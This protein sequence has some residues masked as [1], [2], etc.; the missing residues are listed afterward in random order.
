MT[1]L[2]AAREKLGGGIL[3]RPRDVR[4]GAVPP[5]RQVGDRP[6]HPGRLPDPP[7][8]KGHPVGGTDEE[9]ARLG[10]EGGGHLGIG[11][12][13]RPVRPEGAAGEA[14]GGGGGGGGGGAGGG[15]GR[16]LAARPGAR[17]G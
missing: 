16:P 14:A 10:E 7:S 13:R 1:S 15:G 11:D 6:R 17:R 5:P 2:Q 9:R 8:G 3:E 4:Q 12:G